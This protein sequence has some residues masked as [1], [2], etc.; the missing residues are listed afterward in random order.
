MPPTAAD[1]IRELPMGQLVDHQI[2]ALTSME[3]PLAWARN[4]VRRLLH[5]QSDQ[6]QIDDAV[7]VVT[8]LLTNAIRHAGGPVSLTLDRFEKGVTVGVTDRGRDIAAL[9]ADVVCPLANS[10]KGAPG[11][12]GGGDLTTNGRGLFLVAAFAS[13]WG[14]EP[15]HNG[16]VVTAA[17]CSSGSVA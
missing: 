9:P 12:A 6:D 11:E 1:L 2:F 17:F 15:A 10:P 3:E 16:K 13:G 8:E 5:G 7:L 14:V 4:T